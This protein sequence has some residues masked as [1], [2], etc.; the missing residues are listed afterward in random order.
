[1]EFESQS[2]SY[3]LLRNF[4]ELPEKAYGD[5][6]ILVTRG[7]LPTI[8]MILIQSLEDSLFL[9][10]KIEKNGHTIFDISSRMETLEAIEENRPAKILRLDFV[11]GLSWK[12]IAYLGPDQ[13][14]SSRQ[15]YN[16]FYITSS[17]DRAVHVMYHALL[18]KGF[19][20]IRYQEMLSE[21]VSNENDKFVDLLTPYVGIALAKQIYSALL[22]S[23][24][25]ELV[26]IRT[27][28]I[29][30]LILNRPRSIAS[31][32][33]F[34]LSRYKRL[35]RMILKPP[36]ILLATAGPDGAGK[37]TLLTAVESV[38]DEAYEPVVNQYMGWKQFILPTKKI[39]RFIQ[40]NLAR[41]QTGSA[42]RGKSES[43][44][45]SSWTY[46]FSVL[47][48]FVDLWARYLLRIRPVLVRGG[49][50]LCD[51][52]FYDILA[53]DAWISRNPWTRSFL[54]AVTPPPTVTVLFTGDPEAIARRKQEI[55][56]R[57]TARQMD[58]FTV[59]KNR[60]GIVVELDAIGQL[61]ENIM[62]SLKAIL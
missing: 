5:V 31:R 52:Y 60:K 38:L 44:Q 11:S 32:V 19:F 61:D 14:L 6:D 18:D 35:L 7:D 10:K 51:R 24:Y 13:I 54:L 25:D 36:G 3:C 8:E 37:S 21:L 27:S 46:N 39:L 23:D 4:E 58:S 9:F 41:Q 2:V 40:K 55:S 34:F 26:R 42:E 48:Y 49:L 28:L 50:V 20:S 29:A 53:R 59:L 30:R 62:C 56:A 17:C 47:H 16:N 12:G 57:E 22:C 45:Q 15:K 1:M 33:N 43:A